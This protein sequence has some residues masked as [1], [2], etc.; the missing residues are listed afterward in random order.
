MAM[1]HSIAW[2]YHF[3][4]VEYLDYLLFFVG[5][6]KMKRKSQTVFTEH[7]VLMTVFIEH[8]GLSKETIFYSKKKVICKTVNFSRQL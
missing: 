6:F 7:K 3:P 2:S 1:Y 8:R 5:N 4:V